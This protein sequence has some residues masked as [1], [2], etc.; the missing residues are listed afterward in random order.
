[1][2]YDCEKGGYMV[3]DIVT[4]RDLLT[5]HMGKPK[6]GKP[7]YRIIKLNP[8]KVKAV[9]FYSGFGWLTQNELTELRLTDARLAP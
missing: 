8:I 2:S 3:G 5:P 9:R 4:D 7:A 6:P 1:M